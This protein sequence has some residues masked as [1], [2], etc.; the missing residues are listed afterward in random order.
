MADSQDGHGGL[1]GAVRSAVGG[2]LDATLGR[3]V[4]TARDIGGATVRESIDAMEPYLIEETV[5]RI[6]EGVTPFLIDEIVPEVVDGVTAHLID[7]TVPTVIEGVTP[8]LV[9]KLIPRILEGLQPYLEEQFVPQ[10]VTSLMP[11]I[12]AEVAPQLIDALMPKIEAEV[13]P[14]LVMALMPMI[15]QQVAPQIVDSLMPKIQNEVVPTILE[16]IVDDPR[17]ATLIREQSQG[18]ILDA[19]ERVRLLMANLDDVVE[20]LG[21]KV[22]RRPPVTPQTDPAPIPGR[23]QLRA[24]VV[25]RG[26]GFAIDATLTSMTIA[27]TLNVLLGL[28]RGFV[29]E[30]DQGGLDWIATFMIVVGAPTYFTLCWW[31]A[32]MTVGDLFTGVRITHGSAPDVPFLRAAIRAVLLVALLPI[33][34]VG[35]LPVA[36]RHSRR[37]W[38]DRITRT[39][40]LYVGRGTTTQPTLNP[41]EADRAHLQ[42]E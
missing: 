2:A 9:D 35:M 8:E 20:N 15:E 14:Q 39:Q 33:W 37:S 34:L 22:L 5:P 27:L 6:V 36:F 19:L 12:E 21:R 31:F 4:D 28:Q 17:V 1:T 40:G 23:S 13:A 7:T 18:L 41:L 30:P 26:V 29:A 25:S 3:A 10:V 11:M 24:G 16:D 32:G 38:L 42:A